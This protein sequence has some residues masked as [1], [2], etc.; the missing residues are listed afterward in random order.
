MLPSFPFSYLPENF[1]FLAAVFVL[2]ISLMMLFVGSRIIQWLSFVVVG[3][4][5]AWAGTIL[6]GDA[7]GPAG[8]VVGFVGG[9]ALGGSATL[10]FLPAGMG[11][12]MGLVAAAIAMTFVSVPVVPPLVGI[13]GFAYG[14][15]LTD[16]L[17]PAISA[18]VGGSM[19]FEASVSAGFPLAESLFVSA[20]LVVAGT[21]IQ[22]YIS[23]RA[24]N[25]FGQ[26]TLYRARK[27]RGSS[28]QV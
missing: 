28:A 10:L 7:L 5:V 19:L 25:L 21:M 1:G 6:G 8:A 12:A 22:V 4:M 18:V 17:L 3:L 9:F 13:V 26:R 2:T 16:F 11:L 20:A 27:A 23:R 14:Y 15:L 24:G